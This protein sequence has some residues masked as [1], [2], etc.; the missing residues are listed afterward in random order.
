MYIYRVE[1]RIGN[2]YTGRDS[3]LRGWTAG[4]TT[5]VYISVAETYFYQSSPNSST[6]NNKIINCDQCE[7]NYTSKQNLEVHVKSVHENFKLN[8][9]YCNSIFKSKST[10]K[11]HHISKHTARSDGIPL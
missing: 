3:V 8:C 4:G 6:I 9:L 2:G 5:T 7:K 10:F 11:K 1:D